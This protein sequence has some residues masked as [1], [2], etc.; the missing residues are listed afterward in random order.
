MYKHYFKPIASVTAYALTLS[1]LTTGVIPSKQVSA[2]SNQPVTS[3]SAITASAEPSTIPAIETPAPTP[4]TTPVPYNIY[5][6]DILSVSKTKMIVQPGTTHCLTYNASATPCVKSSNKKL[7]TVALCSNRLKIIIP[8]TAIKGA[9]ATITLAVG[10]I[11]KTIKIYIK[12][13]TN[14]LI[15]SKKNISIKRKKAQKLSAKLNT[16]NKK[17]K[18]TD[19]VT[20]TAKPKSILKITKLKISVR[21][22]TFCIKGIKKGS[23]RL[24]IKAGAKKTMIKVKVK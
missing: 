8:P 7:A 14:K 17:K 2:L 18:T 1:L 12:N 22:A 9:T 16:E 24:Y 19:T 5:V 6:N 3:G 10:S 23:A 15:P 21:K 11:K 20:I 13:T 4:D